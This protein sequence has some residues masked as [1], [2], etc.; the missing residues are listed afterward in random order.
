MKKRYTMEEFEKMFV[1]A[2]ATAMANWKEIWIV[3]KRNMGNQ[4]MA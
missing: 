4:K 3:L 2:M 1:D